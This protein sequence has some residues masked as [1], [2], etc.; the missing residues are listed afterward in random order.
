M[1]S[2]PRCRQ[3]VPAELQGCCV[4][5]ECSKLDVKR[6][7]C[8]VRTCLHAETGVRSGFFFVFVFVFC[9]FLKKSARPAGCEFDADSISWIIY[10][11]FMILGCIGF[12]IYVCCRVCCENIKD[13]R[14]VKGVNRPRL[15]LY[16]G[17]ALIAVPT[18]ANA[19]CMRRLV[20]CRS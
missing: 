1:S 15:P 3:R 5:F 2:G 10:G 7:L 12:T 16:S 17:D 13:K 14:S 9:F 11:L 6:V 8:A 18:F 4:C 19:T 20:P